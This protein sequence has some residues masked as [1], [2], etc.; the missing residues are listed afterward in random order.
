MQEYD[1]DDFSSLPIRPQMRLD[2]YTN[3]RPQTH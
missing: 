1:K 2:C 3:A